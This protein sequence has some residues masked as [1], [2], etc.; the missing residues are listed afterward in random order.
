MG[1]GSERYFMVPANLVSV[2][3]VPE[4][5]G[6]LYVHSR[7]V[8][9]VKKSEGFADR[10]YRSELGYLVSMMRRIEIRAIDAH[11][12]AGNATR[13]SDFLNQ[14]IKSDK[15]SMTAQQST[16]EN[17]NTTES[18]AGRAERAGSGA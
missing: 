9:V 15:K 2:A 5:W 17:Q 8:K 1:M 12:K 14:W 13:P 3:E 11:Y 18:T 16:S 7:H 6:L 10:S 4:K